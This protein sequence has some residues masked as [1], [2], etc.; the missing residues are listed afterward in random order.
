MDTVSDI[1]DQIRE[2]IETSLDSGWSVLALAHEMG[3]PQ[4]TLHRY[5]KRERGLSLENAAR[6]AEFYGM[7]LTRPRQP[8]KE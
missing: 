3:I 8:K 1:D 6:V 2:A 7:R 4:P 5:V